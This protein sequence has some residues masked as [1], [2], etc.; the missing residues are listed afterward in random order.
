MPFEAGHST[1][2]GLRSTELRREFFA[3]WAAKNGGRGGIRTLGEVSPTLGVLSN[4]LQILTSK[5]SD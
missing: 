1:W 4:L 2:P 3:A 5:Y